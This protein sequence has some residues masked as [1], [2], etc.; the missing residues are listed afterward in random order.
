[1]KESVEDSGFREIERMRDGERG[2]LSTDI[3]STLR[4]LF[5]LSSLSGLALFPRQKDILRHSSFV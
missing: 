1:M 5:S 4:L 2:R 3:S